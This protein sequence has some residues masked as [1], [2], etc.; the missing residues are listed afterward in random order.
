MIIASLVFVNSAKFQ[1]QRFKGNREI[2]IFAKLRQQYNQFIFILVVLFRKFL[3]HL[4]LPINRSRI[5]LCDTHFVEVSWKKQILRLK[6]AAF[7]TKLQP[8]FL[9]NQRTTSHHILGL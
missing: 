1:K 7:T 5:A 4:V 6:M 3:S 8:Q 2:E 9:R